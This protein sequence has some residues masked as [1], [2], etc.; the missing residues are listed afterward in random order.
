MAHR[1]RKSQTQ[2]KQLSTHACSKEENQIENYPR[3]KQEK[4]KEITNEKE[5]IRETES[6]SRCP[7]R[8]REME[9]KEE[10]KK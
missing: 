9:N 4:N 1:V 7:E 10:L 3:R 8:R 2:L 6:K 5:N